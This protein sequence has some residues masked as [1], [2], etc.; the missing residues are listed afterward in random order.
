MFGTL[1]IRFRAKPQRRKA[2]GGAQKGYSDLI[3]FS[4]AEFMQ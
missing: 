3:K 1:N 4:A 2:A